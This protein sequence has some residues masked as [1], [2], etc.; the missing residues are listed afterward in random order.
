MES[1]TAARQ[2]YARSTVTKGTAF[3]HQ[4]HVFLQQFLQHP[5]VRSL[6]AFDY[7][8]WLTAANLTNENISPSYPMTSDLPVV[9]TSS[10]LRQERIVRTVGKSKLYGSLNSSLESV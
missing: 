3:H 10:R 6:C 4:L 2:F 8:T 5:L 1:E 7:S 9:Q